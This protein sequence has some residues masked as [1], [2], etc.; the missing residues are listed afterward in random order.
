MQ[1][2]NIRGFRTI[3]EYIR[4][5]LHEYTLEDKSFATL[6][7]Y[8]FSER[9]N[10]ISEISD[11][12][13]IK[14]TTYGECADKIVKKASSLSSL[15][16]SI[17]VGSSIGLY[18]NNSLEW[19]ENFWAIL[20]CGYSPLLMNLRLDDDILDDIIKE[21]KVPAV[22]T[23]GKTFDCLSINATDISAHEVNDGIGSVWGESVIF[24]SSGTSRNVKLCVYTAESF[25]YQ[26]CNSVSIIQNCPKIRNH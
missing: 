16:S 13:R 8:M 7:K 9:E 6:F 12:Y 4:R 11:G 22:I 18:M 1:P 17:P 15:L 5:K 14:K 19:I 3:D 10:I 25:Y 21:Y 2:T 24:M 23:D 20:M 26:I